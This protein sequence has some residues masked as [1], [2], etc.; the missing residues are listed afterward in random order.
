MEKK[1]KQRKIKRHKSLAQKIRERL[2]IT[3]MV[4]SFLSVLLF[5]A[6]I[7]YMLYRQWGHSVYLYTVMGVI[8][9][10]IVIFLVTLIIMRLSG[11]TLDRTIKNYKSGLKILKSA[12]VLLNFILTVSILS[13]SIVNIKEAALQY[14]V[15]IISAVWAAFQ[16]AFQISR[17]AKRYRVKKKN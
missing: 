13:I 2:E 12:L 9:L 17:I 6:Y 10:Y 1:E 5:T 3:K 7:V 11:R 16:I 15:L 14:W 8:G 4:F